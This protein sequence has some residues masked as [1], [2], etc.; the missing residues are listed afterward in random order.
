MELKKSEIY[1][2]GGDKGQTSL[3]GGRRVP[4]HH[5]KIEAYG[6]IDECM[7]QVAV[8][9]EQTDAAD[10][11]EQLL[12]ILER[13]MSAA[14]V[15]AADGDDLPANMPQITEEDIQYL[16]GAIDVMD[17][18]L[19]PLTTFILPGG[20]ITSAQAHVARTICRRSE[21]MILKLSEEEPVEAHLIK[22]FNR[23]SDYF[24]VLARHLTYQ[25]GASEITWKP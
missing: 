5:I 8:L 7:A 20:D 1:T 19:P 23:L 21:R 13:L 22:Y 3:L 17:N 10:V 16:E 2:K 14:S 11:R 15:I 12:V 25:K 9:R 4:K 6:T 24:F 18:A